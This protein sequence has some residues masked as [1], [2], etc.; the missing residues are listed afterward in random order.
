MA[1]GSTNQILAAMAD[2]IRDAIDTATA[3]ENYSVQVEPHMLTAPTVDMYPGDVSKGTEAR[4][5]GAEG[6]LLVTVRVRV[7]GNDN[8]ENWELLNDLMDDTGDLSI[9]AALDS[10]GALNG[11]VTS[12]D[13]RDPTGM[14]LYTYGD[15][16][17]P[18]RQFT[19]M[20]VRADS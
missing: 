11:Y 4:A 16:T 20:V 2:A 15:Q 17:L 19:V 18:G 8:T 10:D 12:L 3:T 13:F 5:F 14:V 7:N 1:T 9:A 6:E